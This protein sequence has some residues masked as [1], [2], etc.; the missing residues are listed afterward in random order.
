MVG[1]LAMVILLS[2]GEKVA[3]RFLPLYL[4]VLGAVPS[5]G[6]C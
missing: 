2:L 6:V 3:E 1:L 5:P 4:V